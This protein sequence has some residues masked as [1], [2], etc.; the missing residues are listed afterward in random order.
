M[1]LP[2]SQTHPAEVMLTVAALHVVTATILL[3]ADM[4]FWTL[5]GGRNTSKTV[6]YDISDVY[7]FTY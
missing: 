6:R 4:A 1:G 7:F 5:A 3:Y 2:A